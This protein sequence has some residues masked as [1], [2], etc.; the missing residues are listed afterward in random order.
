MFLVVKHS[1][2]SLHNHYI[3]LRKNN[4]PILTPFGVTISYEEIYHIN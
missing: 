4:S 1:G 3:T 2:T